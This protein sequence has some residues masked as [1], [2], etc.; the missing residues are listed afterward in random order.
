MSHLTFP[1]R[2]EILCRLSSKASPLNSNSQ[3]L[4]TLRTKAHNG[5]EQVPSEKFEKTHLKFA[6]LFVGSKVVFPSGIVR[7]ATNAEVR[8]RS[9]VRL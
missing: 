8:R 5:E 7:F 6:L 1:K 2:D 3:S 9:T 4:V